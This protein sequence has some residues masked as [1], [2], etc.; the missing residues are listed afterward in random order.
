VA[1]EHLDGPD[2][3]TIFEQVGSEAMSESVACHILGQTPR[4]AGLGKDPLNRPGSKWTLSIPLSRE[5]PVRRF[6]GSPVLSEELEEILG[7]GHIPIFLTLSLIN[8]DD[9]PLAVNVSHSK[10]SHF[11][12][13]ES[14]GI[15][16]GKN[17]LML[18]V[19]DALEQFAHLLSA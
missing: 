19:P 12:N 18:D 14:S 6:I 10:T 16:G 9:H 17:G 15:T 5:K 1:Q 13:S 7:E 2:I 3:H 4:N 8:S 11:R